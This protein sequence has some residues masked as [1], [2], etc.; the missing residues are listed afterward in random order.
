MPEDNSTHK[1]GIFQL[2]EQDGIVVM[3]RGQEI[4][5]YDSIEVFV[6]T[7]LALVDQLEKKLEDLLEEEYKDNI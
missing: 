7:H 2:K 4:G 5:R 3:W 6:D 1:T